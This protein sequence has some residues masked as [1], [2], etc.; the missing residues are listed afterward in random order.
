MEAC[1][2]LRLA[3]R[4]CLQAS[5]TNR[6]AAIAPCMQCLKS[7]VIRGSQFCFHPSPSLA[8]RQTAN[9]PWQKRANSSPYRPRK[10]LLSHQRLRARPCAKRFATHWTITLKE[11]LPTSLRYHL[12]EYCKM[13]SHKRVWQIWAWAGKRISKMAHFRQDRYMSGRK[14][15]LSLVKDRWTS[16]RP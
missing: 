15:T 5:T 8:W 3:Y 9:Q 2:S 10:W 13:V 1:F 11:S 12:V 4:T 16:R 14:S 6:R 7:R